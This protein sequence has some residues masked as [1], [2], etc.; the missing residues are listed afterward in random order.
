MSVD[1][2]FMTWRAPLGLDRK[3]YGSLGIGGTAEVHQRFLHLRKS[4]AFKRPK[5]ETI[6][7]QLRGATITT[8]NFRERQHLLDGEFRN[9]TSEV[10][11]L[12][13]PGIRYH[14]NIVELEAITW[15]F[16]ERLGSAWPI[17]IF[18]KAEEGDLATFLDTTR[19]RLL[20]I[21]KRLELCQD[22]AIGML[23]LHR[24][25][26]IHGDINPRNLLVFREKDDVYIKMSDFGYAA[27]MRKGENIDM[28]RTWPW[29][30]PEIDSQWSFDFEDARRTD[31]YSFALVCAYV[32]FH[33]GFESFTAPGE[34]VNHLAIAR[35]E[36]MRREGDLLPQI[37]AL[38]GWLES[39]DSEHKEELKL[40]FQQS[41]S[42]NPEE[43]NLSLKG[44]FFEHAKRTDIG[45]V[46]FENITP[47]F[48][49]PDPL[50][51]SSQFKVIKIWS[52]AMSGDYRLRTAIFDALVSQA[53]SHPDVCCRDNAAWQLAICYELGFGCAHSSQQSADWAKRCSKS[54][55]ELRT[56]LKRLESISDTPQAGSDFNNW[57][58]TTPVNAYDADGI[59][60]RAAEVHRRSVADLQRLLPPGH[61]K[62]Q[63]QQIILCEVL[64]ASSRW[65]EAYG[66]ISV[67]LDECRRYRVHDP[68][69]LWAIE[70]K[71]S[72]CARLDR[73][74]EANVLLAE[75]KEMQRVVDGPAKQF[76]HRNWRV[77]PTPGSIHYLNQLGISQIEAKDYEA[78][79]HTL[80]ESIKAANEHYGPEDD[81][82]IQIRSFLAVSYFLSNKPDVEDRIQEVISLCDE[83]DT[84]VTRAEK[85]RMRI[86]LCREY[87]K[88]DELHE[89][90][91][92]AVRVVDDCR[93]QLGLGHAFTE[94]ATIALADVYFRRN[95]VK[96]AQALREAIVATRQRQYGEN[97]PVTALSELDLSHSLWDDCRWDETLTIMDR[98]IGVLDKAFGE[99]HPTVIFWRSRFTFRQ[100]Y[101][102]K[103]TRWRFII[104]LNVTTAVGRQLNQLTDWYACRR[105]GYN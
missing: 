59:L 67:V 24:F 7:E 35:L 80:L 43:R 18:E 4:L 9:L 53:G 20:S 49:K 102:R 27:V 47:T 82:V 86:V 74:H 29:Y 64:G 12:C 54:M 100:N 28:A 104:P 87:L 51:M 98:A 50:P 57:G 72:L 16:D 45:V 60:P 30:A 66:L 42:E 41:L 79:E 103:W 99:K 71:R 78:A 84:V 105:Y 21:R 93:S 48:L 38:I 33:D 63:Q 90:L 14:P 3:N 19:G 88:Q 55:E 52:R 17:L 40:F 101:V 22:I 95:Q 68:L 46:T 1:M 97:Q 70:T 81:S 96:E 34:D 2:T 32:L 91:R 89:A 39:V 73:R 11:V 77:E 83:N 85:L 69:L 36:M 25:G 6:P 92:L 15:D 37:I 5:I 44:L 8:Q 13:H 31:H 65:K 23:C 56:E 62:I 76:R 26:I 61:H 75:A 94:D 58:F 10:S